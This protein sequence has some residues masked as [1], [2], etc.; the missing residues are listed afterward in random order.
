MDTWTDIQNFALINVVCG[1]EGDERG[2]KI[3]GVFSTLYEAKEYGEQMKETDATF[4]FYIVEIDKWFPIPPSDEDIHGKKLSEIVKSHKIIH[5]ETV[6]D[7]TKKVEKSYEQR[8]DDYCRSLTY[9]TK[10]DFDKKLADAKKLMLRHT[11][12]GVLFFIFACSLMATFIHR[13]SNDT[14]VSGI[15]G[16]LKSFPRIHDKLND[17]EWEM[18]KYNMFECALILTAY[19]Y[20]F[21]KIVLH[22]FI[23]CILA[24]IV[25][26]MYAPVIFNVVQLK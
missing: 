1:N 19:H 14:V 15:M 26:G 11:N 2:V 17:I 7:I 18:E 8:E 13:N 5:K 24:T 9:Q 21:Y 25:L 23:T 16:S 6:E 4:D 3:K 22:R 20:I 12:H 10:R